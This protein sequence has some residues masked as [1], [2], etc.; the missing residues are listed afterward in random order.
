MTAQWVRFEGPGKLRTHRW[1]RVNDAL[2]PPATYCGLY[3]LRASAQPERGE[4]REC[5]SCATVSRLRSAQRR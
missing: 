1:H 5:A 4:G 3:L 2:S